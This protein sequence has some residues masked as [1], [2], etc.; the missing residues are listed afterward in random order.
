MNNTYTKT[1][2]KGLIVASIV[3]LPLATFAQSAPTT[4]VNPTAPSSMHGKGEMKKGGMKGFHAINGTVTT[5]VGSTITLTT[6][7]GI[8]YTVD[9]T[10]AKYPT[11]PVA[12]TLANIQTGDM[13]NVRGT[14]TTTNVAAKMITDKSY[15]DR[16]VFAGHVTAISGNTIT[17]TDMKNATYTVDATAAQIVKGNHAQT[18]ETIADVKIGDRI[19]AIGTINGTTI[20]ATKIIDSATS[21]L[22][23]MVR[24]MMGK[25]N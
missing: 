19:V 10:N 25:T 11:K 18:A 7:A 22:G 24:K 17:I 6:K 16:T 12:E 3:A 9:A 5:I 21:K 4:Q 8:V 23:G 20:T 1:I 14:V 15:F 2:T 13:L